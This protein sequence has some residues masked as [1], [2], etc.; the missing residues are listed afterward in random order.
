MEVKD[1]AICSR[2]HDLLRQCMIKSRLSIALA[3]KFN[4][5]IYPFQVGDEEC[6]GMCVWEGIQAL[7]QSFMLVVPP[8]SALQNSESSESETIRAMLWNHS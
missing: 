8:Q 5:G 2:R 4:V 1:E 6:D 7:N 3:T